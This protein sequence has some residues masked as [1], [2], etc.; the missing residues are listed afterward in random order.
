MDSVGTTF[1]V[2]LRAEPLIDMDTMFE[3]NG[4]VSNVVG[5]G[6]GADGIRPVCLEGFGVRCSGMVL[7]G[8]T[9]DVSSEVGR[10]E[11]RM[12]EDRGADG[13][14]P[15]GNLDEVI[16]AEGIRRVPKHA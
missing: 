16:G 3:G 14:R 4:V 15:V 11:G 8:A 2:L 12:L 13:M 9:S 5:S 1:V 10:T 7:G 6:T